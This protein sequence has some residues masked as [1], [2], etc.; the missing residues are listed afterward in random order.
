MP[1]TAPV[2]SVLRLDPLAGPPLGPIAVQPDRPAAIGRAGEC[3]IRLPHESVSRRHAIAAWRGHQWFLTDLASRH[4]TFINEVRLQPD[5]PTALADGDLLRLGPWVL[6]VGLG[7]AP[8]QSTVTFNDLQ[9]AGQRVARVPAVE[10]ASPAQQRLNLLIDCAAA[11]HAAEDEHALVQA[12]LTSAVQGTGFVRGAWLR[13]IGSDE[14]MEILGAVGD[15]G[16]ETFAF[17]RSLIREASSGQPARLSGDTPL[18]TAHSICQLDIH[19]AL[20]VPIVLGSSVAGYLY[21]D[22]RGRESRV[23][24]EAAGFCRALAGMCALALANLKRVDLER[25]HRVLEGQLTAAREAQQ[26]IM[27]PTTGTI[28]AL[29][30]AIRTRPGLYVAGDLFDL[31][32][33]SG[34]RIAICIG[35][36]AGEGIGAGILMSG[37]QA[38]LHAA[39]TRHGEPAAALHDVNAYVCGHSSAGR[40]VTMWVGVLDPHN[41]SLTWVDAGHGYCLIR[42]AGSSPERM[43]SPGGLPVGVD[44]DTI[45]RAE[46][47]PIGRGDRIVLFSDG[48]AEQSSAGAQRF[49]VDRIIQALDSS[50]GPADDVDALFRAVFDFAGTESLADDATAASI[51][52]GHANAP[53]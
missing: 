28:G 47:M 41:N 45:Y 48:L 50:S 10:L 39:L 14:Q 53:A 42:R 25:R 15:S 19:S 2:T 52:I 20:C 7:E 18:P 51:Q 36:V 5:R 3:E 1:T 32:P 34:G 49:G 13:P 11:I 8:I 21:L 4:G 40:F 29:S 44:P 12:T 31:V 17:S 38:Y 33:L 23:H 9:S 6:R 46:Q 24:P 27:P 37:A 26:F 43:L 22:A 16:P 35:D 30:Y